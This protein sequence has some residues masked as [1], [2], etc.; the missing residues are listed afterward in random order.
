MHRRSIVAAAAMALSLT[1]TACGG[2]APEGPSGTITVAYQKTSTFFQLDDLLQKVKVEYEAANPGKVVQ[3]APIEAEQDQYFAKLALMNGSPETAPDVIYEDSFQVRSDAAAGY[4][5]PLDDR[6]GGWADWA[7]FDETAKRAGLGDD[8]KVYGVSMGTDTRGIFFNKTIFA[9]AGLPAD[10]Q[11][12]TWA[13]VLSAARTIKSTVPDVVPLQV[14]AG[15]AAGEATSMQGVEMLLYGT[16]DTLYDETNKKWLTGSRGFRDSLSFIGTAYREGLAPGLDVALDAAVTSRVS[17]ELIPQGKVAMAIDGSWLPGQWIS[18]ENAWPEWSQTLGLA[19][20]PT[21]NGQAPGRTSMSGGWLLS[22]GANADD[23][24]AAFGF[25]TT[26][27]NRENTFKYDTENSQ[28]AVR[29]DV[30]A[31]PAYLN[32]NP[33]FPFFV[34]LVPDTHFRPATPEYSQISANIQVAAEAVATGAQ[35][36]EQAAAAYDEALPTIVGGQGTRAAG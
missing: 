34:S 7:Q 32:Y 30:A 5:A 23:P 27:L 21:Q 8:G 33:S 17:K 22:V 10:W 35:T 9:K 12:R 31:D 28:I 29:K 18:G 3:L 15:K 26:A 11:P 6:L 14:Y 4:L 20:M 13:D 24:D 36:P 25:I 2:G 19:A 1:L 16:G